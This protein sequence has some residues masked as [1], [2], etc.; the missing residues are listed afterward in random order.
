M[1]LYYAHKGIEIWHGDARDCLDE[2]IPRCDA[3]C[4]DPPYGV[5]LKG[6]STIP[7][8]R[9]TTYTLFE[10]TL[11]YVL[12]VAIP[13]VQ[14]LIDAGLRGALTPGVRNMRCYPQWADMGVFYVPAAMSRGP[15]GF[16]VCNPI[17]YYGKC[18]E[19][20]PTGIVSGVSAESNGHPCPKPIEW[21]TWLVRKVSRDGETILDPFMGSGTTLLAAKNL[22][23]KAIGIE[24]EERYCEIAANRLAQEVLNFDAEPQE[25]QL[26]QQ[27]LSF[28]G[29]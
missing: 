6:K 11:E 7:K 16:Q 9:W 28:G 10:D 13:V 26:P 3:F 22:Y 23:R 29:V 1:R 24:I 15:W 27:V 8:A 19:H 4:T 14:R 25:E 21:M 12:D 5:G 17:L 2:L 18:L 20:T